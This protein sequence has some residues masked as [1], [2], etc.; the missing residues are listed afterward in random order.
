[1]GELIAFNMLAGRVSQPIIRLAQ[2]WTS[3]QQTGV[4]IQRLGD[5]LNTRTEVN[6][7]KGTV[8]PT[9]V[10]QIEL[11]HHRAAMAAQPVAGKDG[12]VAH[13]LDHAISF[14][15]GRCQAVVLRAGGCQRKNMG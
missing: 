9:L 10:G 13:G 14:D 2:L 1:M 15:V 6:Q 5:I 3:F 8:L 11:E 4:S 7:G 12:D